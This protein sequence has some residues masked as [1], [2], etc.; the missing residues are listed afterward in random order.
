MTQRLVNVECGRSPRDPD[1]HHAGMMEV[2]TSLLQQKCK[3]ICLL[4]RAPPPLIRILNRELSEKC[5]CLKHFASIAGS[6]RL[7]VSLTS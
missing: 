3:R 1:R 6:S 5:A 4:S 2:G 7:Y